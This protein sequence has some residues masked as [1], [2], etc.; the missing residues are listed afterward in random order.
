MKKNLSILLA[1]V[2]LLSVTL[3]CGS[4]AAPADDGSSGGGASA[5][6]ID[7][8]NTLGIDICEA[9]AS[10]AGQEA[11]GPNLL[12][13]GET[14][15]PDDYVKLTNIAYG[16]YDLKLVGCDGTEAVTQFTLP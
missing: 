2:L 10:P 4:E 6:N 9:L 8:K 7:I 14:V 13:D 5:G 11:W 16:E 3:A 1:V 15:A 12:A